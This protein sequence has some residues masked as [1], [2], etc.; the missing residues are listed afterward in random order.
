MYQEDWFDLEILVGFSTQTS[1][2]CNWQ[3]KRSHFQVKIVKLRVPAELTYIYILKW[4]YI[5]STNFSEYSFDCHFMLH[6][7]LRLN[8]R[9]FVNIG[10]DT[11]S[12]RRVNHGWFSSIL[13][14]ITR[15]S[16]LWRS[17]VFI[18][19]CMTS[20]TSSYPIKLRVMYACCSLV[21]GSPSKFCSDEIW[22]VY[23]VHAY[24]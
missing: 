11:R 17:L 4:R 6:L 20:V 7:R 13:S 5:T 2:S 15:G 24:F 18:Q 9:T 21:S 10:Q 19:I 22:L 16:T 12:H 1:F 8:L 3:N 14:F 23:M